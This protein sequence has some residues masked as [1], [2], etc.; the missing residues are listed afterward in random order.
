MPAITFAAARFLARGV[1]LVATLLVN[2][3]KQT[4]WNVV[5]EAS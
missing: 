4:Q 3:T 2:G 1:R 5:W